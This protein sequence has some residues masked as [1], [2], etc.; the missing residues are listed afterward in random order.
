MIKEWMP[1]VID[2]IK[3]DL[4]NDHLKQDYSFVK[5]YLVNKNFQKATTE[6]LVDAYI[7]ALE[8]EELADDIAEFMINRWLLKN[9]EVYNFFADEL[10]KINPDFTEL[11][12]IDHESSVQIVE[13]ANSQFGAPKT[14]LF[15]VL[16][17]VVLSPKAFDELAK[18]ATQEKQI[19]EDQEQ[20]QNQLR[21]IEDMQRNYDLQIARITDK[22]EK[23]LQGLQKKYLQ[24]VESLK[25]QVSQLQKK[26]K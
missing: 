7:R 25:K 19:K 5:K 4:K 6:E 3:K 15:S 23:K 2:S 24:D 1:T 22:Y 12:E 13:K 10:K 18:Q 17:S 26:L 20:T 14:Y 11:E 8:E 21:S 16:N 9:T